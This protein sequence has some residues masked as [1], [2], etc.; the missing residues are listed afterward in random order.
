M[1]IVETCENRLQ[2]SGL[3][4]HNRKADRNGFCTGIFSMR[5][6]FPTCGK[7]CTGKAWKKVNN[8]GR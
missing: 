1:W 6:R 7:A 2:D 3:R 8:C 5:A 4:V